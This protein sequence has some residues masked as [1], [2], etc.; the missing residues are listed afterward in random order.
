M[1]SG[2]SDRSKRTAGLV[3]CSPPFSGRSSRDQLDVALAAASMEIDLELFFSGEG[4][5]QLL[6]DRNPRT[7]GLPGG[8]KAWKALPDL[9]EVN[10]WA[11]AETIR[12]Y[13]PKTARMLLEVQPVEQAELAR[14]LAACDPVMVI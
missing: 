1:S 9:C 2:N 4:I 14:R 12:K 3:V 13:V 10:A 5:L 8:I 6:A 11:S 7:G